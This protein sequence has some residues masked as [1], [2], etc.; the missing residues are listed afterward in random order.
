MNARMLEILNESPMDAGGTLIS[1]ERNPDIFALPDL[2][3]DDPVYTGFFRNNELMGFMLVGFYKAYVNGK[4]ETVCH[5]SHFHVKKE[6]RQKGFYYRAS[7]L[8][9]SESVRDARIGYSLMMAGNTSVESF[10]GRRHERY[11]DI[12]FSRVI[13]QG[14]ARNIVV[15]LK[16]REP[17][18]FTVRS[19]TEADVDA[20][21]DL[22]QK[23]FTGRLFAPYVD[24]EVFVKNLSRRPDFGIGNYYVAEVHKRIVGVCAAWDCSSLK[25]L[26]I[27]RYGG[28]MRWVKRL[29]DLL[30]LFHIAP[31]LPQE[32]G[33]FREMYVTDCAVE[34][35]DPA[36]MRALLVRV[37]NDCKDRDYHMVV[38]G[39]CSGDPILNAV[40][41]FV[42]V[43]LKSNL[44]LGSKDSS[45][46]EN[47]AIDTSLPYIDCALL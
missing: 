5:T 39:S 22:L 10:I 23:E 42:N 2:K 32:G 12:P 35:R 17:A 25:Q 37:Y 40:R 24:R 3:Y 18:G 45:L 46:L 30:S 8:M 29:F 31:R 36:I 6:G 33:M 44:V 26:R 47:G 19:A 41:G 13:H 9:F 1:F 27:L 11:P 15:T 7:R 4:P 21:V 38:F 14:D 28:R 43:S 16:K 20:I 34:Q